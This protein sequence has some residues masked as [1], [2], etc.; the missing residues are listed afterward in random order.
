MPKTITDSEGNEQEVFTSEELEQQKTDAVEAFKT[1]NPDKT[2]EV[3]EL[4]EKL[5]KA[6]EDLEK[7][8]DKDQNFAALRKQKDTAEKKLEETIA[9]FDEKI[10]A[11]GEEIK[12][13]VL[14]GVMQ[15][16]YNETLK[17]LSGDDE[18][19]KKKVEFHYKRLQDTAATKQELTKKMTDAYIL[20]T[21]PEEASA[22]S[23][24]VVSSGGMARA[25]LKETEKKFTQEE[26]EFAQKLA[27]AG[28]I[29]L[30]DEDFK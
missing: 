7:A 14:E 9:G 29:E 19:L 26:K 8:S 10:T 15:D 11:K 3:T 16:H 13:E 5:T 21:A 25:N 20:A 6:T 4:Q 17:S 18:E 1:E 22:L 24:D 27:Q 12:K 23:T 30:K 2:A 28:N